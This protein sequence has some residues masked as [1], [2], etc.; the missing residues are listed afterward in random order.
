MW[1]RVLSGE[2]AGR[3]VE[4]P[5]AGRPFILGRV[6]GCDLVIRD[7]RASRQHAELRVE[8]GGGL[9]VVDLGSANGTFVDG[10]RV[11][12]ALLAG[13]EELR[14]GGVELMVLARRPASEGGEA[15]APT[16]SIVG[17]L[18]DSRHAG[19]AARDVGG[20]RRGG[21]GAGR[22]R[23]VVVVAGGDDDEVPQVVRDL[24]PATVLVEA[25]RG[26]ERTATGSG[27]VLDAG[28]GLIVTAGHVIN[29][30]ER[31]RVGGQDATVVA[32]APCEDLALL[33]VRGVERAEERRRSARARRSSRARPW[34][35]SAFPRDAAADDKVTST[36][37]V[38]SATDAQFRDPAPDVPAYTG[39]HPDR[40][41]VEPRLLRRAAGRSRRARGRRERGGA[42]HGL[43]RPPA[44]GPELRDL[45]R[46]HPRGAGGAAPRPLAGLDRARRFGYP[47]TAELAERRLPPGL[48]VTGAVPGTPAASAELAGRGEVLAGVDGRRV[49]PTLQSYCDAM[50]GQPQRRPR[51][52]DAGPAGREDARGPGGAGV[53]GRRPNGRPAPEGRPLAVVLAGGLS[54]RMGRPKALVPLGGR[55]LIAWPLAAA[56]AAGL[57]AV[58]VAKPGS[59]LPRARRPRLGGAGRRPRIPSPG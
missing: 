29:E 13:G 39:R 27:W 37:G 56:Q 36:R 2:D 48:Y 59:A 6:Q 19:G 9:R 53:S 20:A 45:H 16:W 57:E 38:V 51:D 44:G 11:E 18:V 41:G 46:P 4:L 24:A 50:A 10:R 12:E 31:Y 43:R 33:R 28:E 15:P 58:V 21:A 42:H 34:S 26:S 40:H 47:T 23:L 32:A 49:A 30:G 14:I 55:P 5:E 1:L 3:T 7:E 52:D 25:L 54:R 8:P 22:G 17:R 35:R